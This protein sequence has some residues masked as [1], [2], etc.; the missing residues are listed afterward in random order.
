MASVCFHVARVFDTIKEFVN[1]RKVQ[2]HVVTFTKDNFFVEIKIALFDEYVSV[3]TYFKT[4]IFVYLNRHRIPLLSLY[5][6]VAAINAGCI[7]SND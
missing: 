6:G 7:V 3:L 5:Y 1:A 4:E 2:K